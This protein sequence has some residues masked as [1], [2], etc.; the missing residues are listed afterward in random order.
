MLCVSGAVF[1]LLFQIIDARKVSETESTPVQ[2]KSAMKIE[3]CTIGK[4][5]IHTNILLFR[6]EFLA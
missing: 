3:L 2:V 4:R 6:T 5:I 1:L